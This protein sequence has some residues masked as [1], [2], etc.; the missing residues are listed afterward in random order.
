MF[1]VRNVFNTKPGKAKDL[2]AIFKS[3]H[4][5]LVE[6]GI[7]ANGRILTD[8]SATFWT[9]VI[10]TDVPDLGKYFE[11]LATMGNNQK[12]RDKMKGYMDLV[13]GGHREIWKVE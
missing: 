5:M 4:P 11:G 12:L 13:T 9:V 10:E 3:V 7:A 8:A 2:V 1:V 6:A